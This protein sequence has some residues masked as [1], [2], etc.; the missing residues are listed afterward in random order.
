MSTRSLFPSPLAHNLTNPTI[1]RLRKAPLSPVQ[2]PHLYP[3][4]RHLVASS[5]I[6]QKLSHPWVPRTR[7]TMLRLLRLPLRRFVCHETQE[8][9]AP[10]SK[11]FCTRMLQNVPSAS[12]TTLRTS[13]RPAVVINPSALSASYKSSVLTRILRSITMMRAILQLTRKDY[14]SQSPLRVPFV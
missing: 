2:A 14:W 11:L 5:V 10:L 12:C 9:M 8:S 1:P 7:T 4:P 13:T 3:Q 6:V